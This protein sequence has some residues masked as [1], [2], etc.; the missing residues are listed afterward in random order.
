MVFVLELPSLLLLFLILLLLI[1]FLRF[2]F[3]D[4]S[5]YGSTITIATT[6]RVIT[7]TTPG[8]HTTNH[9]H[10]NHGQKYYDLARYG[11]PSGATSGSFVGPHRSPETKAKDYCT[12]RCEVGLVYL[13]T[14]STNVDIVDIPSTKDPSIT[15][16]VRT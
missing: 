9:C 8:N 16:A 3:D 5:E 12:R 15:I 4:G 7:S 1:G 13:C 6:V 11:G 10:H 14:F 2:W